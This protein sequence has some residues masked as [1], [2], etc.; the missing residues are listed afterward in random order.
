MP[1]ELDTN[2]DSN[3]EHVDQLDNEQDLP[4][5]EELP[6]D[7]VE[8]KR[9]AAT[10][11]QRLS[12]TQQ[13]EAD[14]SSEKR[15]LEETV[16]EE[17]TGRKLWYSKW[18]DADNQLKAANSK[19][20]ETTPAKQDDDDAF[21]KMEVAVALTEGVT[22]GDISK[23]IEQRARVIAT[24]IVKQTT[25]NLSQQGAV[26]NTLTTTYPDL[27]DP[28]SALTKSTIAEMERID[29]ENPGMGDAA[30]FELA[31]LRSATKLGVAAKTN[32][33]GADKGEVSK[34]KERER[35]RTAQ[36]GPTGKATPGKGAIVITEADKAEARRM[37]GG[38]DVPIDV[39]K[40]AK[41]FEQ[42]RQQAQQ[43]RA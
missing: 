34:Q 36:G 13:R 18:E 7:P 8:L 32:G 26:A 39:L 30:K 42:E 25:D 40:N 22:L 43:S 29:S 41:K 37:N 9:I 31:T 5:H 17:R 14:L 33:N 24:E 16:E 23:R 27:K 4:S 15:G 10:A 11:I 35:L 38:Q 6:D 2:Q 1:E 19:G 3:E 21:D 20:K 12:A 28:N